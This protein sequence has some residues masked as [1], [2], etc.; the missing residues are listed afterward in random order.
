[1]NLK[2]IDIGTDMVVGS[3]TYKLYTHKPII[4]N[5]NF[6]ISRNTDGSVSSRYKDD[7]WDFSATATGDVD[8]INFNKFEH[9]MK[10]IEIKTL[11]FIIL[12]YKSSSDGGQ[13]NIS[14]LHEYCNGV[15]YPLYLF[16]N[17]LNT[18]IKDIL[19]NNKRIRSYI[20]EYCTAVYKIKSFMGLLNLLNLQSNHETGINYKHDKKNM[21][22][23]LKLRQAQDNLMKQTE[24]IPTNILSIGL[25]QRWKHIEEVEEVLPSLIGFLNNYLQHEKFACLPKKLKRYPNSKTGCSWEYAV[26]KYSLNKFFTKHN[27]QSRVSLKRIITEIQGTCKHL[28]HAYSGMRD[29]EVLRMKHNCYEFANNLSKT[30]ILIS[31]E[32]KNHSSPVVGKWVTSKE[33]LRVIH[34]LKSI[35]ILL[36]EHYKIDVNEMYL[37]NRSILISNKLKSVNAIFKMALIKNSVELPLNFNALK[38]QEK[39]FQELI[40]IEPNREWSNEEE[41][42]VGKIWIFKSHQYRRSLAVYALKSE[43]VS[44]GSLQLQLKHLLKDITLFYGNGAEHA[45]ELFTIPKNHIANEIESTKY[46]VKALT[47]I[48]EVIFSDETLYGPHGFF[49]ENN[50]KIKDKPFVDYLLDNREKTIKQFKN[51]EIAFTT[52]AIG[53]CVKVGPCYEQISRS[54]VS[55]IECNESYHS[56]TKI[57]NTLQVLDN[58]ISTLSTNSIEFH[59]EIEDKNEL[60]LYLKKLEKKND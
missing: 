48:K 14:T 44:L 56:K 36:A 34:I 5:D 4:P 42:L 31:T 7:I 6:V 9:E 26:E 53:G 27:I 2:T 23:L 17:T 51:G 57:K 3:D 52:T 20:S 30:L 35:N 60:E 10:K 50:K 13:L 21:T 24:V 54:F 12:L 59:S 16:S 32:T 22:K 29:S 18:T 15:M 49:I 1:M 45:K 8:R 43:L 25:K 47:Y 11:L 33:I 37:F 19:S 39:D 46:E 55:C 38:I 58:F 28:I 41:F 40:E